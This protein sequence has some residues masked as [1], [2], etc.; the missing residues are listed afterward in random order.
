M[1]NFLSATLTLCLLV[2]AFGRGVNSTC[3]QQSTRDVKTY[4]VDLDQPPRERF[5]QM[6]QDY[7]TE[8]GILVEA[9][10]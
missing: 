7:K 4:T 8:I 2:V 9:Q 6:S 1:K 3:E 5:K 10:K